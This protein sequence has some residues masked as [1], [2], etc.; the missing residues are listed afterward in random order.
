MINPLDINKS[1]EQAKRIIIVFLVILATLVWGTLLV[2]TANA[3]INPVVDTLVFDTQCA[4]G[5]LGNGTC[6]QGE[7]PP[8]EALINGWTNVTTAMDAT[9]TGLRIDIG[10]GNNTF[11][12]LSGLDP[13]TLTAGSVVNIFHRLQPYS[14]KLVFHKDG[15]E[16]SP[17]VINGVTD[18]SGNRPQINCEGA[19]TQ[20]M[21]D[22][23]ITWVAPYGC[24]VL[25]YSR[26]DG[27]WNNPVE[28]M[29]FR[30]LEMYGASS[31]YT[32]DGGVPYY[33]IAAP[34]RFVEADHIKI[35][36]NIFRDNG[37]G[38]FMTSGNRA[39]MDYQI[40]G[41]KFE[42]NGVVGSYLEHNL[43]FQ[44]V[45]DRPFSNVVEGN[46]FGPLR[47]GSSGNSSMKHRGTD[48]IFR[49]NTVI[50]AQRCLDLVEA[51]DALPN[52]IFSTFSAQEILDRYRT[53]YV[54]GNQFWADDQRGFI[55]T[56]GIHVGM[57]TGT[58]NP[59]D[60]QLFSANEGAAE[61]SP[62][63][64]GVGS[65]V[66]FYNNSYYANNGGEYYQS[67]FDLDAGSS[68]QASFTG[69]VVAANNVI[70][71]A[72]TVP[73]NQVYASHLRSAGQLTYQGVN[74]A[75]ISGSAY[76]TLNEGRDLL[77]VD[78]PEITII[79]ASS[80]TFLQAVTGL[81]PLFTDISNAD[82]EQ[83]DLSL[84]TGSSAIGVG[85]ALP[86][87]MS[88]YPVLGQPILPSLGGGVQS[89]ITTTNLGAFE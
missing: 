13:G 52:Y 24:W 43:Y 76:T 51:Q 11:N 30:N 73:A 19:T 32:S 20:N 77:D 46:Y 49:Y 7:S 34:I 31:E 85:V 62:M 18:A 42:G 84:Q 66:Y 67:I 26:E 39:N 9:G 86:S 33:D 17:I 79:G 81:D 64:R 63:A 57:D 59:T 6:P 82:I 14:T 29:E 70:H 1:K 36:G 22:G 23:S 55:A 37:N 15:T 56:Y 72:D 78:D 41:N 16:A 65:P 58:A 50:C 47:A 8:P 44:A 89:R 40:I 83:I 88:N 25:T 28:W 45:S 53:S 74:V 87:P 69:E 68:G 54:Y 27:E 71:F 3:K 4:A 5:R 10:G 12:D 75:F 48:L 21:Q 61:G 80:P 38:L 2:N 35:I 60:E